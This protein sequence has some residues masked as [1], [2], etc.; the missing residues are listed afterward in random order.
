MSV[1]VSTLLLGVHDRDHNST[2][3]RPVQADPSRQLTNRPRTLVWDRA[4]R[5]FH[6]LLVAAVATAAATGLGGSK[7]T[8]DIHLVAGTLIA[9][10]IVLRCTWGMLG[11][12]YARF[13]SFVPGP[14]R[15]LHH[16]G[17]LLSGTAPAHVGHNP[18]GGAMVV[19]LLATLT[20]LTVTGVVVLGGAIKDGP[21]AAF[22]PYDLGEALRRWHAWLAYGL[23]GLVALHVIGVLVESL[24]TRESLVGAMITGAKAE[25]PDAVGAPPRRARSGLAL[26]V[27][28]LLIGSGAA[29][30]VH[31]SGKPAL[32][33]PTGPLDAAYAR[34]CG[35]CHTPHHPSLAAAATWAGVMA[36]LDDH[37]GDN[38]SLGPDAAAALGAYLAANAAERWDSPAARQLG[39]P[40]TT[41]PLRITAT[42]GWQRIHGTVPDAAFATKAVGGKV[43]CANCH[44]DAASGRFAPRAINVPPLRSTQRGESPS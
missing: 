32:G 23:L 10:L 5:A 31:L 38:A 43:N 18:L 26:V 16:L 8:L 39:S 37:F 4:V 19:A 35:A 44:Q 22:T 1:I 29:A 24:R 2:K 27:S 14:R 7:Q 13:A 9:T 20:A 17:E 42:P 30:I 34:E 3:T 25:R 41:D 11:T 15:L 40:A 6:W 28:L 33:V 12:T 21:L 36:R